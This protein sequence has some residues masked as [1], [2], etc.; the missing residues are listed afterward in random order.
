M[1]RHI[2]VASTGGWQFVSTKYRL[3]P[4]HR[5]GPW[6]IEVVSAEPFPSG[7][8]IRELLDRAEAGA[9][10]LLQRVMPSGGDM[11]RLRRAYERI[12]FDFDDA[13]YAVPPDPDQSPLRSL[14]KGAARLMLR[15]S[16]TAS[17]RRRPLSRTLRSVDVC[18]AG[19]EI[20]AGFARRHASRVEVIPTTVEPVAL[21]PAGRPDPPVLV[22][23]GLPDNLRHLRL[24]RGALRRLG[25]QVEFRLR[26]VSS[27]PWEE[28]D[29]PSEFVPWSP[30]AARE[31]LLS[32]T[33]GLAPLAEHPWTRGKCAFRAI[34]Y[35]AHALPCVASPVGITDRVVVDEET[36][37]LARTE[38][39]WGQALR[40]LVEDSSRAHQM[41]VAA[42]DRIRA[43]YSDQVALRR[44]REVLG[45]L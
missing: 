14:V 15:G 18:V 40:R 42:L 16:P 10:L 8:Q 43:L 17:S 34:Q 11:A 45:S 39:E 3:G 25:R 32:S 44:W 27:A 1:L 5:E 26:V 38:A 23:M 4:L 35:G 20:L 33:V 9:A 2:V 31:A 28:P 24:V 22:W 21:P 30:E 13:I 29:V 12:L 7:A 6:P 36:G 41:G 37:Y 19:N